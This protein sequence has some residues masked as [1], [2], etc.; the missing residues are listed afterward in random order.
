MKV[1]VIATMLLILSLATNVMGQ[2][3]K[4]NLGRGYRGFI[5]VEEMGNFGII[6][7]STTHGY[8]FNP[9][10]FVGAGVNCMAMIGESLWAYSANVRFDATSKGKFNP[11]FDLKTYFQK[12]I[13]FNLHPTVGCRFNHFNVKAGYWFDQDFAGFFTIGIGFDFGGRK[14]K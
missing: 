4:Y 7:F 6:N 10:I 14:K 1:K 12:D 11:F 13:F 3:G 5:D 8:Q 2:E 9:H